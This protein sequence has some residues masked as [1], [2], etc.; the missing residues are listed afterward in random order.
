VAGINSIRL[1]PYALADGPH[2][3]AAD[4]VMLDTAVAEG[5]ASLRFY[6]WSPA[7]LSLGYFQPAAARRAESRLAALPWVRRPTGGAI[8]VHDRELTYALALPPGEP[9]QRGQP[10]M[11][12]M[13]RIIGAALESL[14]VAAIVAEKSEPGSSLLCYQQQAPG[15][16]HCQGA[17]IVGSAQ[18]KHR[19]CLLQ[20]GAILLAQSEFTPQ[21]PGIRELTG[22]TLD[23]EQLAAAVAAGFAEATG[24]TPTRGDWSEV[25]KEAVEPLANQKYRSAAW[26][27][28]R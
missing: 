27:E 28:K 7:T 24:W 11:V 1:L 25:E 20:H 14:G 18:R 22:I 9:G 13:H 5:V 8:L 6:G 3:M 12:H 21:L 17:K 26:N 19:Q 4:E 16:L 15:D 2:N 10:W 23:A